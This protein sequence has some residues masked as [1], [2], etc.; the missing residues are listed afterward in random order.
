LYSTTVVD[1]IVATPEGFAVV[2]VEGRA[3]C[4]EDTSDLA[5]I[6]GIHYRLLAIDDSGG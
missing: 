1:T 4:A 3:V 6:L 2:L 5:T